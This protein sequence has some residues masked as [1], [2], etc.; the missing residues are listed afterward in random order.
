[1]LA[2]L[3]AATTF[4]TALLAFALAEGLLDARQAQLLEA[5]CHREIP[6]PVAV[7]A[8]NGLATGLLLATSIALVCLLVLLFRFPSTRSAIAV[9]L[10][11]VGFLVSTLFM[12]GVGY[13]T[14]RPEPNTP[15]SADHRPCGFG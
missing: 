15:A 7:T 8:L 13:E 11:T 6:V 9:P 2:A 12:F 14:V 3:I 1:M 4:G 5:R 10:T